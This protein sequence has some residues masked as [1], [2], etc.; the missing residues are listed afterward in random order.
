MAT[1]GLGI[2][3]GPDSLFGVSGE[4][5]GEKGFYAEVKILSPENENRGNCLEQ[6]AEQ[7]GNRPLKGYGSVLVVDGNTWRSLT[8]EER[9]AVMSALGASQAQLILIEGLN[10][11]AARRLQ[12][13]KKKMAPA[14]KQ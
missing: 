1:G 4:I 3:Y 11:A 7:A 2:V 14:D 10:A 13:V 5:T 6:G 12:Q 9:V 8:R